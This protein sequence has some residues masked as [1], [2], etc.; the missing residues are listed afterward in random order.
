MEKESCPICGG[1]RKV[2]SKENAKGIV[3]FCGKCGTS[4]TYKK[5]KETE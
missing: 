1:V 2:T 5:P 3:Y 4:W